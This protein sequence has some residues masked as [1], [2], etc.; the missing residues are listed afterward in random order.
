[1]GYFWAAAVACVVISS[2]LIV[3]SGLRACGS[4]VKLNFNSAGDTRKRVVIWSLSSHNILCTS[5]A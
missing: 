1:M 3:K 2:A 4:T 5:G